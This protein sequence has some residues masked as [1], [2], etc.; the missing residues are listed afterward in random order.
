MKDLL[1]TAT[2][3][4]VQSLSTR[5]AVLPVGSFEQHGGFHPLITDTVIA[6]AI[7][8][9]IAGDYS[10]FLLPPIT[11]SCSHEHTAFAGTVSISA[12]T[13]IAMIQDIAN[14]LTA[15]GVDKLVIVNGH[16]GNYVLQNVVQEANAGN[17]TMTLFPGRTDWDAARGEAAMQTNG[18]EDMHAGE[19]ET[20]ILLHVAPQMLRP[21]Y[22][23]ADWRADERPF[24]LVSGMQEYTETG[25]IGFPSLG[26]SEKGE[27]ALAS[28]SRSFKEHLQRLSP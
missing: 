10:L 24:L 12:S 16:G 19:L 11:F 3:T 6:S 23:D 18:H 14:S 9:R 26:T 20:S 1:T 7:A 2:S 15:S 28:L 27:R 8:D 17:P 25:V 13:L 22:E 4:E 5:I 21:G